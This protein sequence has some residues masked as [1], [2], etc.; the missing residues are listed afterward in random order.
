MIV[1]VRSYRIKPGRRAE[2]VQMFE[3]RAI[4]ALRS[5]GMQVMGP[6]LDVEN[7]NKFVWL[8]TFPS[9][10]DRDRM[11]DAFYGSDLWKN[12]L[13]AIA[14]PMLDSYDVILCELSRVTCS[15]DQSQT[16]N[17]SWRRNSDEHYQAL[18]YPDLVM[19]SLSY[20]VSVGRTIFRISRE[21]H[22]TTGWPA[23]LRLRIW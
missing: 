14:M 7:P 21:E 17:D 1:E 8:R 15:M 12:E 4:P 6:L 2:F 13:E 20:A 11:K 22:A 19:Q 5:Y 23:R 3:T 9:L 10:E 18:L 16:L